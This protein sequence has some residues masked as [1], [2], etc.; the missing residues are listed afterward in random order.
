MALAPEDDAA[1][2]F[3]NQGE[4]VQYLAQGGA[5]CRDDGHARRCR[6]RARAA[7]RRSRRRRM[8]R[9]SRRPSPASPAR[10]RRTCHAP[11][12]ARRGA[13]S[14]PPGTLPSCPLLCDALPRATDAAAPCPPD[15]PIALCEGHLAAASEW[16][17]RTYGVTD[18]LP[19][20][21]RA[22]RVAARRAL[23]VGLD[24]R[25]LRMA[26]RRGAGR[27]ARAAA[28]RRRL[29]PPLRRPREDRH[30]VESA[31]AV[32]RDLARRDPRLRARRSDAGAPP[33]RRVRRRPLP[34][35]RVV[36]AVRRAA[37]AHR[38]VVAAGVEDP[39][40]RYARWVSEANALR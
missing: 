12:D 16:A 28:H 26:P 20:P 39:W 24:L 40:L 2:P 27:R 13:L 38:R 5:C 36:P 4:C 35:H 31:S 32:R 14:G 18:L 7:R 23:P 11:A 37:S 1:V 33:A 9:S 3:R 6:D 19:S 8:P 29:L 10:R 15:A 25:G 30:D 21:C 34:G 17:D 22:L